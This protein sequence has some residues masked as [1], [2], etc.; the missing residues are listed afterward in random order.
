MFS[1]APSSLSPSPS[2]YLQLS[3]HGDIW[4]IFG[5][6]FFLC[7]LCYLCVLIRII[8]K[9]KEKKNKNSILN[10]D[11]EEDKLYQL[12]DVEEPFPSF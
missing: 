2:G 3:C 10:I 12:D 1:S 9:R 4:V 5:I 7:C 11:Y 6:G 8:C